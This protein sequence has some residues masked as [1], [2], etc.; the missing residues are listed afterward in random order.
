MVG[1]FAIACKKWEEHNE[2]TNQDLTKTLADEIGQRS[3]L[4]KFY[5]Y[6]KKTGLEKELASSKT[7]T[8]WAPTNDALQTLDPAIV[9]DT[10][11]LR[12]FISNHIAYQSYFVKDAQTPIRVAMLNGKRVTFT[13][14]KFDDANIA[15]ADKYVSNGVLH[16]IDNLALVYPNA[17]EL[18]NNTK[19]TYQQSAFIASLTRKVFDPTNAIIDSISTV[20]G[21]P[22]YRPG[23][24]SVLRN[25]FNTDVYDLQNEEKQYTYFILNDAAFT[26]EVTKL[27]P[28]Y[29][30]STTDS[31]KNLASFAVVKDLAVEGVYTISQLPA[32]LTSRYGVKIPIDRTKIVESRRMSNGIAYIMSDVNF[33]KKEKIPT[34]VI[35]GENYRGFFD[36]NG[37]SVTP[38]QNNVSAIFLRSRITPTG[39]LFNDM[40]AY[41]H[42]IASLAAWYR[43][44]NIAS[45]KYKVYWMAPNDTLNV[46]GTI[47]PAVFNQRLAMGSI[48]NNFLPNAT[49]QAV[50]VNNYTEVYLG[51]WTTTTYGTLNMYLTAAASAT[52]QPAGIRLNLDYIK[53]VPDL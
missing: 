43:T 34:V 38:R 40:F 16:I 44:P 13:A 10:A 53:L 50:A 6:V 35:E 47:A 42:G 19:T 9:N 1:L 5:E 18:T 36:V 26:A 3:N 17:W 31:T 51:D 52:G 29:K 27:S 48:G 46:N 49:G 25:A 28:Y 2:I 22:V 15:T 21:Q 23:T 12:Q 33:D 45:V 32:F 4:T 39:I 14:T 7:Y 30:T 24:D 37:V 8:V 20:T 11:R 41:N